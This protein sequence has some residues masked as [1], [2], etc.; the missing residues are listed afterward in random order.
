MSDAGRVLN[1]VAETSKPIKASNGVLFAQHDTTD[2]SDIFSVVDKPLR[3]VAF[4]LMV[5]DLVRV[6]RIW[7][8]PSNATRGACGKLIADSEMFEQPHR[9][10]ISKVELTPTQ[11]EIVIDAK[12]YYRLMYVGSSRPEVQ[13]ISFEDDLVSINDNIRGI[14]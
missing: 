7:M 4:G 14:E 6:M 3:I 5:G 13:V 12:G 1:V 9:V 10:G 2:V 8:S 11:T